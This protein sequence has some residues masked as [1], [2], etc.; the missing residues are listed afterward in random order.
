MGDTVEIPRDVANMVLRLAEVLVDGDLAANEDDGDQSLV[1]R[2]GDEG[3]KTIQSWREAY[4][5]FD[6]SACR[7]RWPAVEAVLKG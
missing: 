1:R 2:F 6:W 7:L 5:E 3:S 4:Q